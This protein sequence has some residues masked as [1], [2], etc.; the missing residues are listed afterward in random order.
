MFACDGV[1]LP[2]E[3]REVASRM[4]SV[5]CSQPYPHPPGLPAVICGLFL[6]CNDPNVGCPDWKALPDLSKYRFYSTDAVL[7]ELAW[8]AFLVVL[9]AVLPGKWVPGVKLP[10][11]GRLMYKLNGF[12]SGVVA[13]AVLVGALYN[14]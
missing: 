4:S 2:A 12:L 1:T 11:G 5:V 3:E 13:A 9:W 6:F 8:F 14:P 10:S 7:V